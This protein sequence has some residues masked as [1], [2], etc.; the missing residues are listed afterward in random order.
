M[1]PKKYFKDGDQRIKDYNYQTTK[2]LSIFFNTL[3]KS[4]HLE[5]STKKL[6]KQKMTYC[7]ANITILFIAPNNKLKNRTILLNATFEIYFL[8]ITYINLTK[9]KLQ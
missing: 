5:F 6:Y 2:C 9:N 3:Y 1:F 8:R 4:L 7:V